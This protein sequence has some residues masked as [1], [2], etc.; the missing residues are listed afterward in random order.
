MSRSPVSG[1]ADVARQRPVCLVTST[2]QSPSRTRRP[3]HASQPD[4]G[5]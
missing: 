3:T 5:R 1:F 2:S 4:A